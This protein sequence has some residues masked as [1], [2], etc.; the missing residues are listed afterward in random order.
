MVEEQVN[1]G[2]M[3]VLEPDFILRQCGFYEGDNLGFFDP[4]KA[5]EI[6]T[7]TFVNEYPNRSS[8]REFAEAHNAKMEN[9]RRDFIRTYRTDPLSQH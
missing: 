8:I 5:R 6:E 2:M 4:T 3:R 9:W 7:N 1:S